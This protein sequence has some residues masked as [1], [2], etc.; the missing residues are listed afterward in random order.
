VPV[1]ANIASESAATSE[2]D[3]RKARIEANR[4]ETQADEGQGDEM[5]N[6]DSGGENRSQMS[7]L[8]DAA[9]EP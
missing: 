9:T 2:N 3:M 8:S 6:L 5:Q 4:D 7:N 1:R